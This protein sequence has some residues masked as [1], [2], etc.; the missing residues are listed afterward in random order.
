MTAQAKGK[1]SQARVSCSAVISL[2]PKALSFCS[3]STLQRPWMLRK[4][5]YWMWSDRF[6]MGH[7]VIGI[8]C[9]WS[10]VLQQCKAETFTFNYFYWAPLHFTCNK[11]LL[12]LSADY[13]GIQI[14]TTNAVLELTDWVCDISVS[15]L[16]IKRD[17]E[18]LVNMWIQT[19][20]QRFWGY[21]NSLRPRIS[22]HLCFS[23]FFFFF[24]FFENLSAVQVSKR[25]LS[26]TWMNGAYQSSDTLMSFLC[27][28]RD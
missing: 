26:Y 24:L 23:F 8:F 3:P 27:I 13:N 2:A 28:S 16:C 15:R 1:Q 6:I 21:F 25:L 10:Q 19:L 7:E 11:T 20:Q 12:S 14:K 22:W 4:L 17:G 5:H 9:N 18:S